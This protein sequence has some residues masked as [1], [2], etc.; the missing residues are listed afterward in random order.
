MMLTR[1]RTLTDVFKSGEGGVLHQGR[2]ELAEASDTVDGERR[3]VSDGVAE[4][5]P[6]GVRLKQPQRSGTKAE[7]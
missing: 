4:S 7:D 2:V 5:V 3:S 6:R 1:K